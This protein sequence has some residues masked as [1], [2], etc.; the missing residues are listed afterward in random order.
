MI[1]TAVLLLIFAFAVLLNLL[2][3]HI[4]DDFTYARNFYTRGAVNSVTDIFPSMAAH[5]FK[6]NGRTVP[7]FFAQLF[8][9]LPKWVFNI[10]N[11]AVFAA[12]PVVIDAFCSERNKFRFCGIILLFTAVWLGEPVFGEVNLWLTGACNYLWGI[13]F[14]LT[15]LLPYA[16]AEQGIFVLDSR[17]K[18]IAFALFSLLAG[19]YSENTSAAVIAAAFL[20]MLIVLKRRGLRGMAPYISAW[21]CA[22]IGYIVMAFSPAGAAAKIAGLDHL[23]EG[24]RSAFVMYRSLWPMLAVYFICVT[25]VIVGKTEIRKI[26]VSL[27]LFAASLA[28]NFIMVF[29]SYYEERSLASVFV[30]LLAAVYTVCEVLYC[31]IASKHEDGKYPAVIPAAA[32]CVSLL[33]CGL[34]IPKG[35]SEIH[36][37]Y[38]EVKDGEKIILQSAEKGQTEVEIPYVYSENKYSPLYGLKYI[39][40]VDSGSWPNHAM[41]LY[42]GIETVNGK[43]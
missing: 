6:M 4:V 36:R 12:L 34:F 1:Y 24:I 42:Y 21:L 3:P 5:Y 8:M 9:Y 22:V 23:R 40:T 25:A 39:D 35:Y 37:V 18:S 27:T 38:A 43:E 7:H 28:A 15:F 11:A 26:F 33:L 19:G 16:K 20:F 10:V 14:C 17:I 31:D 29:A 2:T 30:F 13:V 41:A 32:V